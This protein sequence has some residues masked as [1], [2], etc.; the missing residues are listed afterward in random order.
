M[1]KTRVAIFVCSLA[2]AALVTCGGLTVRF[3]NRS[4]A[5]TTAVLKGL[6]SDVSTANTSTITYSRH[7]STAF[8]KGIS[9]E[10]YRA[11][12]NKITTELG[13]VKSIEMKTFT[14][15]TTTHGRFAFVSCHGV[16]DRGEAIISATL[17]YTGE[18]WLVDS[19]HFQAAV[20]E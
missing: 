11:L 20:P 15:Q 17:S 14:L 16:F 2:I 5:E 9:I 19:F 6:I 18:G 3:V 8:R 12:L 1:S 10:E 7:V 4:Q 13:P